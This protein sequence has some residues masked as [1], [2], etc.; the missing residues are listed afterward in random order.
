VVSIGNCSGSEID[1]FEEFNL[2]TAE[3][4]MVNA[5]L[6]V[7]CYANFE[8]R[9]YDSKLVNDYNFFIFEI[10]KAHVAKVPKYPKT[11]HYRGNSH[12]VQ[13]GKNIIIRSAK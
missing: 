4:E 13:S 3:G 11:I 7:N 10:V 2:N 1:K 5:P 9:L 8:C 12:F 6:L